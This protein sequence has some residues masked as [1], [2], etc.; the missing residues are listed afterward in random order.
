MLIHACAGVAN[1][2][3]AQVVLDRNGSTIV[4]QAYAPDIIR[5]TLSLDKNG[6]LA[7]PGY[8]FAATPASAGWTHWNDATHKLDHTGPPA[9]A[10]DSEIADVVK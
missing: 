2:E 7:A 10:P 3:A 6:A 4:P 1:A 5:V 9:W 8:G